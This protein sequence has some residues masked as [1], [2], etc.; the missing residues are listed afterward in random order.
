[1]KMKKAFLY[2]MFGLLAVGWTSS[3]YAQPATYKAADMATWTYTWENAQGQTQTSNYVVWNAEKEAYETPE[4]HDAYQIYGLLRAVYMNKDLPGPWQSAY[5]ADGVTREDDVFYGGCDNGWNIPGTYTGGTT[6]TIGSLTININNG[7]DNNYYYPINIYG[8][9]ITSGTKLIA[10]WNPRN[11]LPWDYSG[12][13]TSAQSTTVNGTTYYYRYFASSSGGTITIPA[14]L[15]S[16]YDNIEVI[17]TAGYSYASSATATIS[18]GGKSQ[19]I[20]GAY[21]DMDYS[22]NFNRVSHKTYNSST[23]KPNEE[24]YTAIAVAL[25]D[26]PY[27]PAEP[28]LGGST[29]YSDPDSVINYIDKNI[30][31]VKLLTDGLRITD[32][33]GNPGT[34]FNCDGTYNKFFFLGKGKARQKGAE[35]QSKINSGDWAGYTGECVIF[36]PLFEEFS[37]TT[38]KLEG[39]STVVDFYDRMMEGS[40]YDVVHDCAG[41]IQNRHE[42]TLAGEDQTDDFPF[43]GMNFFIPDYRLKYWVGKDSTYSSSTGYTYYDVDGRDMNAMY[44]T[45]GSNFRPVSPYYS[46]Y[47]QYNPDYA[48]KVGIYK[49][50]LSAVATFVGDPENPNHEPG[51]Q[52]YVVTLTWVSSLNEM[53]GYDVEQTY[54]VYYWDPKTGE[55]KYVVAT[56]ITNGQTGLTTVS[57]LVD[58][59]EHSYTIEYIVMGT[60]DDSEHPNFVAWS[61]RDNVVIPGWDDFVGLQL[62]HH[63]SDFVVGDMANYYRNFLEVVNEDIYNGLTVSKIEAGMNTFT[64]YRYEGDVDPEK[65]STPIARITFGTPSNG[66]VPYTITYLN[67]QV[68]LETPKYNLDENH[69][70]IPLTGVVRVKGNGDIVIWPNSY[71]V[72][73]KSIKIY[74]NNTLLQSWEYTQNNLPS[75]WI[76]SPGSEW[77]NFVNN[78]DRVGYMEG[79]GYIAIP[80]MLNNSNYDNLRV[81]IVAYGDGASV[82]R[83]TVNDRQQTIANGTAATYKW[84]G[85]DLNEHPLSPYAAPKRDNNGS[86]STP[87]VAPSTTENK[88]VGASNGTTNSNVPFNK[89]NKR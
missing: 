16:G 20:E 35:V 15:T 62:D 46:N 41:V 18:V 25:K 40:V 48:P 10:S 3:A 84:G 34:V 77:E 59:E 21:V 51:N 66:T 12:S 33:A 30:E 65:P 37:P 38:G 1:M 56:G 64:L 82:A 89:T 24:G 55:R 42:F 22:W 72:N 73:F 26:T 27:I 86:N 81:E 61:N 9:R 50:T 36:W 31:F 2:L 76:V 47:A 78:G 69:L 43:T 57:Y 5:K 19:T 83:I 45:T 14:S 39:A 68:L 87:K 53:A 75:N 85:N 60:P 70:N 49:I 17:I 11:S 63:E 44:T 6:S 54:T 23:Y 74:N 52:N 80:N 8:I 32:Q 7:R 4:V 79:G 28:G 71:H 67:D 88:P 29:G 58:Q 13:L